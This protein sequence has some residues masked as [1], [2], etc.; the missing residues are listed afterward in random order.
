MYGPD[1]LLVKHQAC[2][3]FFF[4]ALPWQHG[5]VCWSSFNL[6]TPVWAHLPTNW[7]NWIKKIKNWHPQAAE[8]RFCITWSWKISSHQG[9][10][11]GC[12]INILSMYPQGDYISPTLHCSMSY[13]WIGICCSL[14]RVWIQS[15]ASLHTAVYKYISSASSGQPTKHWL[16]FEL[17]I[18]NINL[19]P[20]SL[21]TV[22][23]RFL[24][25]STDWRETR[26]HFQSLWRVVDPHQSSA[27]S[28]SWNKPSPDSLPEYV[29]SQVSTQ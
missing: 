3:F 1:R 14:H 15:G 6:S 8:T 16:A 4:L 2:H 20:L 5:P 25:Q 21:S 17:S 23:S 22:L 13:R 11:N 26:H 24:C 28:T 7:K 29:L 10:V 18:H 19:W 9:S 12:K 27:D